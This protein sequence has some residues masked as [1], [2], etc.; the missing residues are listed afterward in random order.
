MP[1]TNAFLTARQRQEFTCQITSAKTITRCKIQEV[2]HAAGI[3]N[4]Q[5]PAGSTILRASNATT[6]RVGRVMETL[7]PRR[8]AALVA[9]QTLISIK[10]TFAAPSFRHH[11]V[12]GLVRL[13][14]AQN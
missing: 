9:L 3:R 11:P 1:K 5:A 12:M 6:T 13:L 14:L 7:K 8:P 4:T 10:W 2:E